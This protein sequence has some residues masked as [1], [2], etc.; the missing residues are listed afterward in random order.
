V[1]AAIDDA[2]RR[3]IDAV[4][5]RLEADGLLFVGLDVIGGYL[6]EVNVTSPTGLQQMERLSGDDLSGR[7]IERLEKTAR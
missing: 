3:I 4:T 6:T 5:P 7:V 1:A 2:D